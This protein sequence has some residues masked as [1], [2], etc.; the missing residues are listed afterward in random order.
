LKSILIR[1]E[2]GAKTIDTRSSVKTGLVMLV[3]SCMRMRMA[4]ESMLLPL[5]KGESGA[6]EGGFEVSVKPC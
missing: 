3:L 1:F 4:D 6:V 2:Y 5:K